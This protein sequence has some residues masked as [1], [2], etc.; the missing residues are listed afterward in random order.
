MFYLSDNEDD[1]NTQDVWNLLNAPT[2]NEQKK[3]F[4]ELSGGGEGG[5]SE[6]IFSKGGT[7]IAQFKGH[8]QDTIA[9]AFLGDSRL[10]SAS[11]DGTLRVWDRL[12]TLCVRTHQ[13]PNCSSFTSLTIL[14][15]GMI[16]ASSLEG[17]VYV[18][19][20]NKEDDT[21]TLVSKTTGK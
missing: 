8:A 7:C 16:A 6:N 12:S 20:L 11:K 14:P 3:L 1:M 5:D 15:S 19:R 21:L 2:E 4:S 17:F 13:E 18:Y 10:I 9:C